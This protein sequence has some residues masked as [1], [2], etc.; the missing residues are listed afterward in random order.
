M[1]RGLLAS[2]LLILATTAGIAGRGA[3]SIQASGTAGS[4][5]EAAGL[6]TGREEHTATLLRSGNVLIAGGTDGSA[7]VGAFASNY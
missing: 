3:V 1:R 5:S 7:D 4:W 6:I 2:C